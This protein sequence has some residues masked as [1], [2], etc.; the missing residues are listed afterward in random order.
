MI[1]D[2]AL[3][4]AYL[5]V[6]LKRSD[7]FTNTMV[8]DFRKPVTFLLLVAI[9]IVAIVFLIS[10]LEGPEGT[11]TGGSSAA[12]DSSAP[13][14]QIEYGKPAYYGSDIWINTNIF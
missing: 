9:V 6:K 7:A 13:T 12:G 3:T 8:L 2:C 4:T 14:T 1:D 10:F 5:M 11:A